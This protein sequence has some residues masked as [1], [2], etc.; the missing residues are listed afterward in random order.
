M[1]PHWS[2]C[3][4]VT[5]SRA[6]QCTGRRKH[7]TDPTQVGSPWFMVVVLFSLFPAVQSFKFPL[8]LNNAARSHYSTNIQPPKGL[9]GSSLHHL[10]LCQWFSNSAMC[11]NISSRSAK[12]FPTAMLFASILLK[13]QC[14]F[15][16][17]T[18]RDYSTFV[19][20]FD[21]WFPWLYSLFQLFEEAK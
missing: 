12:H 16:F 6:V 9:T 17:K 7:C 4:H 14:V 10:P 13:L 20:L 1:L 8:F 15:C 3:V 5:C 18:K 2:D 11:S 19:G 21:K